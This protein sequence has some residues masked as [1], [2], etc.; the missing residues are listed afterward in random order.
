MSS[1]TPTSREV[2]ANNILNLINT[3]TTSSNPAAASDKQKLGLA[4]YDLAMAY[5]ML[6]PIMTPMAIPIP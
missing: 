3:L 6:I 5:N 1:A 4:I 2:A